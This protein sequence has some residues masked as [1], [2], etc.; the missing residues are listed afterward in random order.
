MKVS[1]ID[2]D[3]DWTFGRGKANYLSKGPAVHQKVITR[4]QSFK[5]DWFLNIDD[6]IDWIDL[7]GRKG[8]QDTIQRE[9]ERVIL[10]TYG[11]A[12]ID[13]LDIIVDN[14]LRLATISATITDIYSE[15][16][17]IDLELD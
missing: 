13:E 15:T 9:V 1:R 4:L 12:R 17:S 5:N 6:G 14:S 10:Q 3:N 7:L 8:T 2:A 11:V 16:F